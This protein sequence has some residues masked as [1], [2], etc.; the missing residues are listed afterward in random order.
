MNVLD[1]A[2]FLMYGLYEE[3][4]EK[5]LGQYLHIVKLIKLLHIIIYVFFYSHNHSLI[6]WLKG[7][8]SLL[9]IR[10]YAGLWYCKGNKIV[11]S[12]YSQRKGKGDIKNY[13]VSC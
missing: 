11:Q 7:L 13:L 1:C 10:H 8:E 2:Y 5:C 12:L 3:I 9:C 6:F 4:D